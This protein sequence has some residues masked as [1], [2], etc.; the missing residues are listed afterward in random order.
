MN[1]H[2]N[3]Y[4]TLQ[5]LFDEL[6]ISTE[7]A[8]HIMHSANTKQRRDLSEKVNMT[9]HNNGWDSVEESSVR[10]ETRYFNYD[11]E[12]PDFFLF[13]RQQR[14][15]VIHVLELGDVGEDYLLGA[16]NVL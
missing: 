16:T 8:R 3:D 4:M 10:L 9:W 15:M 14:A 6:D 1:K 2:M 11:G 13:R 5:E 12:V 7:R